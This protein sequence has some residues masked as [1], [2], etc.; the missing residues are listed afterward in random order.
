MRP[1]DG[2]RVIE[3]SSWMATPSAG[4]IL[5]DLGAEVVKVEPLTG[6]PM[7]GLARQPRHPDPDRPSVD[8]PFQVDNRGKRSMTLDLGHEEAKSVMRRL[9]ADADVFVCNLLPHRQGR[10]G[11]T[12]EELLAANPRLVHATQTGYGTVGPEAWRPGFDV[13]AFFGRGAV[14]DGLSEPDGPPPTPRPAQGDHTTGLA[15]VAGILAALRAAERTGQG[16]VI[17]TSLLHASAWTLATELAPTLIDHRQ[18]SRRDRRHQISP[19]NNRFQCADEKWLVLTMP[20]PRW[21][22]PFCKGIGRPEWADDPRYSS[23]RARY[24]NGPELTDELDAMFA[25]KDRD[26]WGR[27]LDDGGLIW[28]PIQNQVELVE[29]PQ[30]RAA[31]LWT[32]IQHPE[33]GPVETVHIPVRMHG[34]DLSPRTPAPSLGEHTDGVLAE[35]GY[36][37]EEVTALRE[38]GVVG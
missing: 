19:L 6:D 33:A 20:E 18:P 3:V 17:E 32:E 28:G 8:E 26:E 13:T 9:V 7:R 11:V 1:L 24:E 29:D 15:L 36:T 2:I 30:A 25:T 23:G 4:A 21:W 27:I 22:V 10:F 31:G 37:P 35:A 12:A 14:S 38:A 34:V 16:Q 5:A